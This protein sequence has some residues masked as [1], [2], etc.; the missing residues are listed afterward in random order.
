L[1]L[2]ERRAKFQP[3][4]FHPED[5]EGF[6][7]DYRPGFVVNDDTIYPVSTGGKD[8]MV[9]DVEKAKEVWF[10]GVHSDVCVYP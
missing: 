8:L 10:C 1:A 7:N 3:E 4:F 6:T 5:I 2:D 9:D